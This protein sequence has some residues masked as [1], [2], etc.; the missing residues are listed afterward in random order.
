MRLDGGQAALAV[1][2][3]DAPRPLVEGVGYLVVGVAQHRLP[4]RRIIDRIGV[5]VPVP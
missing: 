2:G 4:V 3:M 5:D 1:V